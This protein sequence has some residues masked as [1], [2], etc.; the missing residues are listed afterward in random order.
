MTILVAW[1]NCQAAWIRIKS[2]QICVYKSS[3][4]KSSSFTEDATNRINRGR[5]IYMKGHN[6][7]NFVDFWIYWWD[8]F[9]RRIKISPTVQ[10]NVKS[11]SSRYWLVTK[12]Y[13]LVTS[14][15]SIKLSWLKRFVTSSL[16][17]Y[18]IDFAIFIIHLRISR[19]NFFSQ[20][21]MNNFVQMCCVFQSFQKD[22]FF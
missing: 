13:R 10:R 3:V 2:I 9:I 17:W 19:E 22:F 21:F 11:I 12:L 14:V 16:V 4:Y 18:K 20:I 7:E 1:K 8:N 15:W 5:N 6:G